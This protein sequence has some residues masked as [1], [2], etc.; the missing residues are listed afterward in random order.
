[1]NRTGWFFGYAAAALLGMGLVG[2]SHEP[3]SPIVT[4][5]ERAG[6]G[7][8]RTASVGAM[9]QWF[10]KHAA[11]AIEADRLCKGARGKAPA[12]WPETTEGHVC[13]AAAQVAGFIRWRR[14]LQR[15]NDHKTFQGGSK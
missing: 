3:R 8:L 1:M 14:E 10:D 15:N 9:V 5:V 13:N 4:M 7:D 6:A 2:C 12:K 11:V